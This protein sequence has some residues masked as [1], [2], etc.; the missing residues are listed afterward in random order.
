MASYSAFF[1]SGLLAPY[2]S[3]TTTNASS[4][5]LSPIRPV[6]P[7]P[8]AHDIDR[9]ATPTPSSHRGSSDLQQIDEDAPSSNLTSSPQSSSG[10]R[11][12][13][14]RSSLTVGMSPMNNIRSPQRSAG[15]AA[16]R[17]AHHSISISSPSRSRS[18]SIGA[19]AADLFGA[20]YA[21]VASEGTSLVGRM[22]SGS[23]GGALKFTSP[24][25]TT[26]V[27]KFR[28]SRSSTPDSS[29]PTAAFIP[30]KCQY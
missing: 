5:D 11:L 28:P 9:T 17:Y 1:S 13:K 7:L 15:A 10:P 4:F 8:N 25:A 18:G 24:S 3:Y 30:I 16:A 26:W 6:S 23:V 27:V 29:S 2:Q 20:G 21:N 12:R 19:V 14:R 22:R